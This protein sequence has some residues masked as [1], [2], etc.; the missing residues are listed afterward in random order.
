M[1]LKDPNITLDLIAPLGVYNPYLLPDQKTYRVSKQYTCND[2]PAS[3][4]LITCS[5]DFDPENLLDPTVIAGNL[6]ISLEQIEV[7][8]SKLTISTGRDDLTFY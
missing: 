3:N 2:T 8:L 6:F 1:T 4:N 5:I 7:V